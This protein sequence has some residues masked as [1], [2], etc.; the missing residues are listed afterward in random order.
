MPSEMSGSISMRGE[1]KSYGGSI[2]NNSNFT[3]VLPTLPPAVLQPPIA[4]IQTFPRQYPR[5]AF[6]SP[7]RLLQYCCC[8]RKDGSA[9]LISFHS[10][11]IFIAIIQSLCAVLVVFY[12]GWSAS[13]LFTSIPGFQSELVERI[14]QDVQTQMLAPLHALRTLQWNVQGH[15]PTFG[16]EA[17]VTNRTGFFADISY[18]LQRSVNIKLRWGYEL[19]LALL[20][21]ITSHPR[22]HCVSL[23]N[24][25]YVCLSSYPSIWGIGVCNH[26]KALLYAT[27]EENNPYGYC[28]ASN[29]F[30]LRMFPNPKHFQRKERDNIYHTQFHSLLHSPHFSFDSTSEEIHAALGTP[31]IEVENFDVHQRPYYSRALEVWPN[32][33]WLMQFNS[34]PLREAGAIHTATNLPISIVRAS[35]DRKTVFFI[36]TDKK[37]LSHILSSIPIGRHGVAMVVDAEGNMVASSSSVSKER[38]RIIVQS[39]KQMGHLVDSTNEMNITSGDRLSRPR[40]AGVLTEI[41]SLQDNSIPSELMRRSY[42]QLNGESFTL[43]ARSAG[44]PQLDWTV[45]VL[46]LPTDFEMSYQSFARTSG[47]ISFGV[48]CL[49]IF[50][51]FYLVRLFGHP[52]AQL[53]D[54]MQKVG[55]TIG[56]DSHS[57]GMDDG[58]SKVAREATVNSEKQTSTTVASPL[59]ASE[60]RFAEL[61]RLWDEMI[62]KRSPFSIKRQTNMPSIP[63]SPSMNTE[64]TGVSNPFPATP[65]TENIH[66]RS[67]SSAYSP[68][69]EVLTAVSPENNLSAVSDNISPPTVSS[70][71]MFSAALSRLRSSLSLLN[72]PSSSH[73]LS[74][75]GMRMSEIHQLESSFSSMLHQISASHAA[76]LSVNSAKRHFIRY[77]FHEVRVPFNA[78]VLAICELERLMDRT[79][80]TI[81]TQSGNNHH[82]SSMSM[83][84]RPGMH[85]FAP[86]SSTEPASAS[87]LAD[88][89]AVAQSREILSI[90]T[91]QSEVV[92]R[93]LNDVL[94]LQRIE[95][96][97]LRL[98][99]APFDFEAML[100]STLKSFQSAISDKKLQVTLDI[101][102]L[103]EYMYTLNGETTGHPTGSSTD[104]SPQDVSTQNDPAS[105]DQLDVSSQ[106]S[107][108]TT[109]DFDSNSQVQHN[110][111]PLSA[112]VEGISSAVC[113]TATTVDGSEQHLLS[114]CS[115]FTTG[116]SLHHQVAVEKFPFQSTMSSSLRDNSNVRSQ[117][118]LGPSNSNSPSGTPT[119]RHRVLVK[120][121]QAAA[122]MQQQQL[123][124]RRE[125]SGGHTHAVGGGIS[126]VDSDTPVSQHSP[127][128]SSYS[129]HH[130]AVG[131]GASALGIL[132]VSASPSTIVR[133][134]SRGMHSAGT[135][136]GLVGG[137][138]NPSS[139]RTSHSSATSANSLEESD[140]IVD[141]H[142]PSTSGGFSHSL[143]GTGW[144]PVMNKPRRVNTLVSP[145][146]SPGPTPPSILVPPHASSS[147]ASILRTQRP[148]PF[149]LGDLYRLRQIIANFVSN[150]IKFTKVGGRIVVRLRFSLADD[151]TGK[152]LCAEAKTAG[153]KAAAVATVSSATSLPPA[154][155]YS[156]SPQSSPPPVDEGLTPS[157]RGKALTLS[158]PTPLPSSPSPHVAAI[159]HS[160][161]TDASLSP[162]DVDSISDLSVL[163]TVMFHLSVIDDGIGVSPDEASKLF[164][165]FVQLSSGTSQQKGKGS[166]LGLSIARHLVSLHGG[167]IGYRAPNLCDVL[168]TPPSSSEEDL[169][170]ASS[171]NGKHNA[172]SATPSVVVGGSS[173]GG[174][175]DPS[176]TSGSPS[177]PEQQASVDAT[178]ASGPRASEFW[179]SVPMQVLP[180][181]VKH[182]SSG[183]SAH[184]PSVLLDANR[185]RHK[186]HRS[187]DVRE[188]TTMVD[189]G[190]NSSSSTHSRATSISSSGLVTQ[191]SP[192]TPIS[193]SAMDFLS[194]FP[195]GNDNAGSSGPPSRDVSRPHSAQS[196][197]VTEENESVRFSQPM[198]GS[199]SHVLYNTSKDPSPVGSE[200]M[201]YRSF[202]D[203]TAVSATATTNNSTSTF[204]NRHSNPVGSPTLSTSVTPVTDIRTLASINTSM[205]LLQLASSTGGG[206]GGNSSQNNNSLIPSTSNL[207]PRSPF[208]VMRRLPLPQ[209]AAGVSSRAQDGTSILSSSGSTN[210]T[211]TGV[212]AVAG[213]AAGLSSRALAVNV[214]PI[215]SPT[216]PDGIV[217][218]P[219]G[220]ADVRQQPLVL[221][222]PMSVP[223]VVVGPPASASVT[224]APNNL[225]RR[226]LVVEDSLPNLKL[227]MMMTR[228]LGYIVS[229]VEHGGLCVDLFEE[230]ARLRGDNQPNS[231]N[232]IIPPI[233]VSPGEGW[234]CDCILLDG[235]MP[236]L[237]GPMTAKHLRGMGVRI[238]IIG[239]F[240]IKQFPL[241][242]HTSLL[243]AH[244]SCSLT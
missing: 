242:M 175:A 8:R 200:Q 190:S 132:T 22:A 199:Q 194:Q 213:S 240:L 138:T 104:S 33:G 96:G 87:L 71:S 40:M 108:R 45:V 28:D 53:A 225:G 195:T 236:V 99:F 10:I 137:F 206:I 244:Y 89:V 241:L 3:S 113:T 51:S 83:Q 126:D 17:I 4:R 170:S 111:I 183:R 167:T 128:M 59:P 57:I 94:S 48:L 153:V 15:W 234:P 91:E 226:I 44:V 178:A 95:E 158:A 152:N 12:L 103:E 72:V 165:P 41:D 75:S 164:S 187:F 209:Q 139:R 47:L 32:M 149:C 29:N 192:S 180:Q 177:T 88:P 123:E 243:T 218:D 188:G 42:L 13:S 133:T 146:H 172:Q 100:R 117:N 21:Q 5:G 124:R 171:A 116:V 118:R 176:P 74:L 61:T 216:T 214:S 69:P 228:S 157:A 81:S 232:S 70:Q 36:S 168:T 39:L 78:V 136:F 173:V 160:M 38:M 189:G 184:L 92:V 169:N 130:G 233:N 182:S 220:S 186:K 156:P 67:T 76:L 193:P 68:S 110:S 211:A 212:T 55:T 235:S 64:S 114:P 127:V 191:P 229:G 7:I 207:P 6:I 140:S 196:H 105:F 65:L 122:Q 230:A 101:Q 35:I 210:T 239:I 148:Q 107:M 73:P 102:S 49:G 119:L 161:N 222:S 112:S 84:H 14:R 56:G 150:A 203:Q 154:S 25:V 20:S 198:S 18:L 131:A 63:S 221:S 179:I 159:S 90:L 185:S 115:S 147:L 54:F 163:P 52:L 120:K 121:G 162:S 80:P 93:I 34:L 16:D 11:S 227:L 217:P 106:S 1:G 142:I 43:Y 129:L 231:D 197:I 31:H 238:P 202:A 62:S 208:S 37:F 181:S 215:L 143:H 204:L 19:P 60:E 205:G 155:S 134:L 223:S 58:R 174:S 109:R 125:S 98:E 237:N 26:K 151:Q 144:S 66:V 77:I 9:L 46:S 219:D 86:T 24:S 145:F 2:R 30:T 224:A 79:F 85:T 82:H 50:A 97:A 166:G 135:S 27:R 201:E 141:S 23:L